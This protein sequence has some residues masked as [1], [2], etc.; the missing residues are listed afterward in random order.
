VGDIRGSHMVS[1]CLQLGMA[2]VKFEMF[3]SPERSK[4]N[5]S[6]ESQNGNFVIWIA[7]TESLQKV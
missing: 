3:G 6:L 2:C 7:D 4:V 5:R 1:L